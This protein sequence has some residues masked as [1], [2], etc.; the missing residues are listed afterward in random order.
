M[1]GV[2]AGA[3]S[4]GV[5][6]G[7]VHV[8]DRPTAPIE[9]ANELD[10]PVKATIDIRTTGGVLSAPE[11]VYRDEFRLFPTEHYRVVE[12]DTVET[13]QY[14]VTVTASSADGDVNTGPVT[15]IW[16]RA[17]CRRQRL[18]VRVERDGSVAFEQR[19][20]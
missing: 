11:R 3:V 10:R 16:G 2:L 14:E 7:S 13:G 8:A 17:G 12:A 19:E 5:I 15:T 1:L 18:I 4:G 20:C 9:W 6:V